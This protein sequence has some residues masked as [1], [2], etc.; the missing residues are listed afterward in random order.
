MEV[1]SLSGYFSGEGV[2]ERFDNTFLLTRRRMK[3]KEAA[4]SALLSS[5]E[6]FFLYL[7]KV[8]VGGLHFICSFQ[9]FKE[10][11][12]LNQLQDAFVSPKVKQKE[13]TDPKK[14]FKVGVAP[15][16]CSF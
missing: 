4:C 11:Q 1:F 10:T 5:R 8:K 15:F 9:S 13:D 6:M 12:H 3:D 14:L 16:S 7:P 2:L